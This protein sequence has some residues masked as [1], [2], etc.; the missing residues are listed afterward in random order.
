MKTNTWIKRSANN[1]M[2]TLFVVVFCLIHTLQRF[3]DSVGSEWIKIWNVVENKDRYKGKILHLLY[4]SVCTRLLVL[5][6][7]MWG[8]NTC[9]SSWLQ[10]S[11]YPPR[12]FLFNSVY[13]CCW[14]FF[15]LY[16]FFFACQNYI[17]MLIVTSL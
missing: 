15:F 11:N 13:F 8:E 10:R 6:E 14:F 2:W 16:F 3:F 12:V 5:Y 4:L 1:V 17:L 7:W 9:E